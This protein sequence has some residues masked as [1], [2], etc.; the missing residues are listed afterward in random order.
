MPA[1]IYALKVHEVESLLCLP[2]IVAAVAK[3]HGRS[4]SREQYLQMLADNVTDSERHKVIIERWKR[5]LEPNLSGIISTISARPKPLD[6]L[7]KDVP[8]IF[9]HTSW[10]FSPER[11][12]EEEKQRVESASPFSSVDEFLALMPGKKFIAVAA[13]MLNMTDKGYVELV[14]HALSGTEGAIAELGS[15]IRQ[16]LKSYLPRKTVAESPAKNEAEPIL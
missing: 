5:R 9:D 15:E 6:E 13:R 1:G 12:L 8:A 3:Y 11:M 10:S 4:F 14:I 7:V 2:D 16:V